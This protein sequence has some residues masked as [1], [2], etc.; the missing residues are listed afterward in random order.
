[1]TDDIDTLQ[2]LRAV[3]DTLIEQLLRLEQLGG[4]DAVGD[5]VW[6]A[7]DLSLAIERINKKLGE[8]PSEA[9]IE[10][11]RRKLFMN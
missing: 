7:G 1:M 11:L 4:F 6:A 10:E 3:R 8:A 9:E 5:L 2:K